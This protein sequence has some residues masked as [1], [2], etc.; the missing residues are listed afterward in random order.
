[1]DEYHRCEFAPAELV[2][3][4]RFGVHR[5]TKREVALAKSFRIRSHGRMPFVIIDAAGKPLCDAAGELIVLATREEAA[6]WTTKG[7]RVEPYIARRHE[8][9]RRRDN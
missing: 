7:E 4:I 2:P 6:R 1:L 5:A 8:T 3:D 9:S